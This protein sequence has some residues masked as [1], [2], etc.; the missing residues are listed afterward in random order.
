MAS[1]YKR[2]NS[3][4]IAVTRTPLYE[5]IPIT[6]TLV[7][8]SVYGTSNIKTYAH[9][10]FET[11]YDYP[12]LSSSANA[13]F[14]IT[15][16]RTTDADATLMSEVQTAKKNNIYNQMSQIL[17]GYDVDGKIKKFA[18]KVDIHGGQPESNFNNLYFLNFSRL[19]VKDEIKKG[20]FQVVFGAD[21]SFSSPFGSTL[22][23][24]DQGAATSYYVDSPTGEYGVLYAT[25]GSNNETGAGYDGPP[26]VGYVFYQ[27]G[28]AV[29][30]ASV[31]ASASDGFNEIDN[32][33][34]ND[35]GHL[36]IIADMSGTNGTS[37]ITG[38]VADMFVSA[39]I[40]GCADAFRK[41]VQNISFNN[42]TELNSTIYF[43]RANHNEFNYSSNPTYLDSSKIVVKQRREDAPISY[44]TTV[45]LYS[46]DNE[47][48]AVAKV[49][50]PLKKTPDDSLILRVRLD[51]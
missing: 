25:E 28:V 31:F 8:S 13:L 12:Y 43:C 40:Q 24:K 41:R 21:Q 26:E 29:I 48:L 45:G 5:A 2:L 18:P 33:S 42:T 14:D 20:T 23:I 6:G 15:V 49:S 10:M 3:D 34:E 1:T 19:L 51:V 38:S 16:G 36:S 30:N 50:E 4:D 32:L 11:V 39:S 17:L 22:T 27:A 7:S 35:K 46:V 47:L 44:I 37:L 9:G